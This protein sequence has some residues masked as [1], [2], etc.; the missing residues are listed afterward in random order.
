MF[1]FH[2]EDQN[3][4]AA[5]ELSSPKLLGTYVA[6]SI[7]NK[8][9]SS[10]LKGWKLKINI[11]ITAATQHITPNHAWITECQAQCGGAP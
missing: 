10:T 1:T 7:G 6:A 8:I 11:Y 2:N 3:V 4:I 5:T 9:T